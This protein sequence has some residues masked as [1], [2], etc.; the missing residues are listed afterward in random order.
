MLTSLRNVV[1]EIAVRLRNVYLC[2]VWRHQ[3]DPTARV[4]FGAFLDRTAGDGIS[5]GAHTLVARGAV[6]LAH[7]FCRGKRAATQIGANCFIGVNAVILPG[8]RIADQVIVGAGAIVSKDVE[9]GSV[10]AGNPAHLIRRVTT[11]HYGRILEATNH[12]RA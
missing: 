3:I 12:E 11:G 1:R 10:V 6:V 2:R 5:I 4:S 8:V 7:D 9:Q